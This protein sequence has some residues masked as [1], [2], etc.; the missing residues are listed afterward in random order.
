MLTPR[1]DELINAILDGEAFEKEV[2]ELQSLVG[3]DDQLASQLADRIAEHR[4]LGLIYQPFDSEMCVNSIMDAICREEQS[5]TERIVESV[6]ES[7]TV[8]SHFLQAVQPTDDQALASVA[9]KKYLLGLTGGVAFSVLVAGMAWF[10]VSLFGRD[11]R[12]SIA[13]WN[14]TV[15]EQFD[16]P[17]ATLLLE[18]DCIWKSG[19]ELGEGQ[20][21][22]AQSLDL[23]SGVA[24]IRFDGGA[25]LV[26]TG[27]TSLLLLSAGSAE[28]RRGD[29]VVRAEDGAEGFELGTPGSPLTDL[30][31]EFAVRV[32]RVGTTE[33]HVLDGEV[34]YVKGD[35]RDVLSA[36]K[37]IRFAGSTKAVEDVEL[38]SPR[39]AEVVKRVNPQP[40]PHRMLVYEGFFYEPGL[41]PLRQ[42]TKGKGW[43]GPW[44]LRL[45][46]ERKLPTDESSPKYFEIVHGQ[47]NITWPVPGGRQGMLKLPS[48]GVYYVRPLQRSIDLDSDRVT[49]FSLMVRE[50]ERPTD[51][52]PP[53]E[54]LRLT[55]RASSSYF[56]EWVSFGHG[57]G[58]RPRVQ[59]GPG[60]SHTSSVVLPPEQTTLWIGKIVSRERGED[61]IYFRV[62][63]EEDVLGYAEPA[64]WHVVSRGV[65]LN[66]RLDR[67]LL[68][69]DGVTARIVDELRIGPTWRSVAPMLKG[70]E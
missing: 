32:D 4:L 36:G 43:A 8:D 24:V 59:S 15:D 5:V 65:D 19:V 35:S 62:Y 42:T 13:H 22:A 56:D 11:A 25:E 68:S 57:P 31:T 63:G 7:E 37:A 53:R 55:F 2:V 12:N 54:R 39:F 70:N 38:N 50:T 61:E 10:L 41:L 47:M 51:A 40:Q 58:Y 30:G 46:K 66:A 26:M 6:F 49:Y 48:G 33:V 1:A 45:R 29:V 20:R 67:V 16:K 52:K 9:T 21:L 18:E 23:R 64:D 27:E 17:V 69:S 34:E 44:R 3:A 28:L 60:V 14:R